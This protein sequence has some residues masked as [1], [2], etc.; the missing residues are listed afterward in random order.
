MKLKIQHEYEIIEE[1]N[2]YPIKGNI[3]HFVSFQFHPSDYEN[4]LHS[5]LLFFTKSTYDPLNPSK[6]LDI[7]YYEIEDE[8]QHFRY[9]IY[10][11][12]KLK[13]LDYSSID[14]K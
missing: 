8:E 10:I 11:D 6:N 7:I 4:I 12:M 1:E 5:A 9:S 13:K 3:V 14:V 2:I